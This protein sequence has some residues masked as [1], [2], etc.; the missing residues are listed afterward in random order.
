MNEWI[1]E[2]WY[3]LK[4]KHDLKNGDYHKSLKGIIHKDYHNS[5][6]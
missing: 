1:D 5:F 3:V 2:Q 6:D 4:F